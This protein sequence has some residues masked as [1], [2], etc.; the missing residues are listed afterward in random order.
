[1]AGITGAT[2]AVAGAYIADTS[3]MG[4]SGS[5]LRP[6]R[7]F[8]RGWL[9]AVAPW[10]GTVGAISLPHHSL[11]AAVLNGLKPTTGCSLMQCGVAYGRRRPIF[12]ES[13]PQ[14][15]PAG[16]G[17][18]IVAHPMTVFLSCSSVRCRCS[19]L[20]HF[21]RGPLSLER[22]DDRPVVAVF[23]I[24][25]AS[26]KP[27]S[28]VPPPNVSARSRPLSPAWRLTRWASCWRSRREAGWP[29]HYDSSASGGIRVRVAGHAVQ[30]GR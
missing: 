21:R 13:Q 6:R 12:P 26:L 1:V 19:A 10:P 16:A 8:R 25:Y 29:S 22:D 7:L 20:G 17:H 11:L 23:G 14:A 30:A 27:S 28:L 5:P 4:R 3:P 24:S 9:V 2:G 15:L 18:D